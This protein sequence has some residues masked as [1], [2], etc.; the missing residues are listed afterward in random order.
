[1]YAVSGVAPYRKEFLIRDQS[2]ASCLRLTARCPLCKRRQLSPGGLWGY[3]L[4]CGVA[5]PQ[6]RAAEAQWGLWGLFPRK[7]AWGSAGG[8]VGTFGQWQHRIPFEKCE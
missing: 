5:W 8:S 4:S 1:M 6:A 7:G 3:R 2:G